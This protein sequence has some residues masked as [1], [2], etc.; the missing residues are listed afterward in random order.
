M[1]VYILFIT[2]S[3]ETYVMQTNT[4]YNT[5]PLARMMTVM[6]ALMV[7]RFFFLVLTKLVN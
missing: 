2:M 1:K 7:V 5:Q 4:T 6:V 3:I